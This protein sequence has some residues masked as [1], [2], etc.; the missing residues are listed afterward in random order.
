MIDKKR[1][2]REEPDKIALEALKIASQV[3]TQVENEGI[4]KVHKDTLDKIYNNNS[5]PNSPLFGRP[6]FGFTFVPPFGFGI[7]LA[8]TTTATTTAA[9]TTTT[10]QQQQQQ[11]QNQQFDPSDANCLYCKEKHW[12]F[13]CHHIPENY[14]NFCMN[15]W[16]TKTHTA[17]N[18]KNS[19]NKE[20]WL[21]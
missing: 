2:D 19:K 16:K 9:A 20:P 21:S 11:Q 13:N 8:A 10:Q 1:K 14:R 12:L 6:A 4:R 17:M 18:C 15:C 3:I 5:C 7:K